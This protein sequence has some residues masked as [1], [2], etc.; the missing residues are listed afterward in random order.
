VFLLKIIIAII[1]FSG[2]C[3]ELEPG[4]KAPLKARVTIDLRAASQAVAG[5]PGTGEFEVSSNEKINVQCTNCGAQLDLN[6][7]P[8][9]EGNVQK[10]S[11]QFP[12][13][14][15]TYICKLNFRVSFEDN[16]SPESIDYGLYICPIGSN[17][18]RACNIDSAIE[19]CS[20]N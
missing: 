1:S 14:D 16:K 4:V 5:Q 17:G 10:A 12:F 8:D 15:K 7:L 20:I 19:T 18:E 2:A 9:G 13:V 11:F 6:F 3:K